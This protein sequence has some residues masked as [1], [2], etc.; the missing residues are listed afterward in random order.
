[1]NRALNLKNSYFCI[2]VIWKIR[3]YYTCTLFIFSL[4]FIENTKQFGSYFGFYTQCQ[5]K[6]ESW[7]SGHILKRCSVSAPSKMSW[8]FNSL[9]ELNVVDFWLDK[10][11]WS[12]TL[13]CL[14]DCHE[15]VVLWVKSGLN[16]IQAV[17]YR[18]WLC[19]SEVAGP[20]QTC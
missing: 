5:H 2:K 12:F 11:F 8:M 6:Q 7:F 18:L 13:L 10:Q 16:F 4:L 14:C 3:K 15:N 17:V 9:L 19:F 20:K 1:M